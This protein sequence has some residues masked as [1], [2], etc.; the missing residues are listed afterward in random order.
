M[1]SKRWKALP[2][3]KKAFYKQA[4]AK[5][6]ARYRQDIHNAEKKQES[7]AYACYQTP[8]VVTARMA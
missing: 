1:V 2:E 5:D 7:S 3:D 8:S 4:A 6:L